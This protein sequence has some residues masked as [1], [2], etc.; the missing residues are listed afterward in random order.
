M[1]DDW[2]SLVKQV[3][4]EIEEAPYLVA[5]HRI[6]DPRDPTR[7]TDLSVDGLAIL[8]TV[9]DQGAAVYIHKLSPGIFIG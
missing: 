1:P 4:A 6:P 9:E 2:Q 8:Y 7:I 3:L 5:S